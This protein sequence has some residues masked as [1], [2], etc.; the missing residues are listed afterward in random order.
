VNAFFK[1]LK[2]LLDAMPFANAGNYSEFQQLLRRH[3][4]RS[5]E[6]MSLRGVVHRRFAFRQVRPTAHPLLISMNG[7]MPKKH[8]GAK[9]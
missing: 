5:D 2:Q 3:N 8:S 7:V 4:K 6:P 1:T 9:K